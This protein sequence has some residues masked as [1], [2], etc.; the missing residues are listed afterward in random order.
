MI[1]K[2]IHYCWFGSKEKDERILSCLDSWHKFLP[3][4]LFKEWTDKDL[5]KL[6]Y[7]AYVCQAYQAK[8]YAFVSDVFRLYA[9]YTE[10]G[11]YF[12]TD[13]EVKKSFNPL[14]DLDFFIG[15]ETYGHVKQI[16]TAVIGS[17]KNSLIIERLLHTYDDISFIGD[18]GY[19]MT[20]N[21][22]RLI[23]PLKKCGFNKVYAE[24]NPIYNGDKNVIF[25]CGIFS[26]ETKDSFAVHHFA[27]SWVDD[28]KRQ[29]FKR[30]HLFKYVFGFYKFKKI[31][32]DGVFLYPETM[33]RKLAEFNYGNR[34]KILITTERA[35]H[36][37]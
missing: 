5:S 27:S 21:T 22:M 26:Q 15:S 32:H 25:P 2:I 6:A 36:E 3:D 31:K 24:V 35:K 20:P 18:K 13:V 8:K 11:I 9:L 34:H 28:F 23:E 7:N 4:Y 37:I 16:G 33:K 14:L 30:I 17:E 19:D 29:Y 1:P 12:D 10:G